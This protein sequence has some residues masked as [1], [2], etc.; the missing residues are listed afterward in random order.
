MQFDRGVKSGYAG[1]TL[2]HERP[3]KFRLSSNCTIWMSSPI[4][5]L[6]NAPASAGR[7]TVRYEC[8]PLFFAWNYH[9]LCAL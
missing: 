2:S 6:L 4:L 8:R 7:T 5:C 9:W 1:S 3:P